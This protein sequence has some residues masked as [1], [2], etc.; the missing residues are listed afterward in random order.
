MKVL[1]RNAT[2]NLREAAVGGPDVPSAKGD[3]WDRW[4]S[5][6]FNPDDPT[7]A[8]TY[9]GYRATASTAI[10]TA[11]AQGEYNAGIFALTIPQG[12]QANER[13]GAEVQ[14]IKDKFQ[15]QFWFPLYKTAS[16]E[17]TRVTDTTSRAGAV[18]LICR[19]IK[20]RLVCLYQTALLE[21]GNI[22]Y[23][24]SELFDDA[25]NRLSHFKRGDA[26][27]YKILYDK[28]RTLHP[29][30]YNTSAGDPG[31]HLT[32]NFA[33][34]F[35]YPRR[36]AMSTDDANGGGLAGSGNTLGTE[37]TYDDATGGTTLVGGTQ[38][39][40]LLWYLFCDDKHA[41]SDPVTSGEFYFASK[42][43]MMRVDRRTYWTDV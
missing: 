7:D 10:A 18:E 26:S 15:F 41:W 40:Q 6:F 14:V 27:G 21:P 16:V 19:P 9:H 42:G 33:A 25:T 28:T 36:Y 34:N 24:T 13:V 5:L 31:F 4:M 1:D 37:V 22:G 2:L 23:L 12:T 39:G 29:P 17:P 3:P 30:A 8:R 32:A 38:K 43:L 35:S 11:A 20:L